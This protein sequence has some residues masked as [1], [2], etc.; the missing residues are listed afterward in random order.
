M[1]EMKKVIGV[2]FLIHSDRK[3]IRIFRS[4]TQEAKGLRDRKP[5]SLHAFGT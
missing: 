5:T 2:P 1:P 3:L 4:S